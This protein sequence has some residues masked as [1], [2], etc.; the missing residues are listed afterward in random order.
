MKEKHRYYWQD[1]INLIVFYTVFMCFVVAFI[2]GIV[3]CIKGKLDVWSVVG[4]F[5]LIV[6]MSAP[7]LIKKIFKI[8]FSRVVTVAFY[9]IMFFSG[10]MGEILKFNQN[11]GWSMFIHFMFGAVVS[12]LSIYILNQ[13]VYKK[14]N[15]YQN[16]HS[17]VYQP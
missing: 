16:K 5:G 6:L 2:F 15:H 9:L 8:T 3:N 14:D 13:T 10:F 12:V 4:R 11:S 17:A 1:I 7:Y